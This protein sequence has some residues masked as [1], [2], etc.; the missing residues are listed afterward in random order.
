MGLTEEE[1][2]RGN[3]RGEIAGRTERKRKKERD[4]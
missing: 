2:Q 4:R 3:D 1:R